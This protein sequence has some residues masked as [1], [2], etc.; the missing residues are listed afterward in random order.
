MYERKYEKAIRV[1]NLGIKKYQTAH[2]LYYQKGVIEQDYFGKW[3]NAIKN[4]TVKLK[5]NKEG[6]ADHAKVYYRRGVCLYKIG[7]Y[8]LS[9]K[10]FNTAISL[11]SRYD[12]AYLSRA[13]AYAKTGR[14]HKAK[15]DLKKC[16]DINPKFAK[17]AQ[18]FMKEISSW[19]WS[20]LNSAAI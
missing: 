1:L 9:I 6:R 4:Y 17:D 2:V 11:S 12:K 3:N 16:V 8:G 20:V 15:A 10:D 14:I 19:E 7:A 13:K 18:S 5:L